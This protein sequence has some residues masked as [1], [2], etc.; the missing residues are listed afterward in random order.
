M[1]QGIPDWRP[2]PLAITMLVQ[3]CYVGE[4]LLCPLLWP[5]IKPGPTLSNQT[6]CTK[7]HYCSLCVDVQA[8]QNVPIMQDKCNWR[9]NLQ[10]R[11]CA[12]LQFRIP[13][14]ASPP[15]PQ[16]QQCIDAYIH[17]SPLKHHKKQNEPCILLNCQSSLQPSL[18]VKRSCPAGW[19][20]NGCCTCSRGGGCCS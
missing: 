2:W 4:S 10:Q 20:L 5:A 14:P 11:P 7:L 13:H 3:H 17:N 16:Q 19:V 18:Q 15:P 12:W 8:W 1:T 6:L 9:T